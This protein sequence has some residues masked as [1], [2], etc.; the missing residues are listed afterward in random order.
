MTCYPLRSASAKPFLLPMSMLSRRFEELLLG[1]D[2]L[3]LDE[4]TLDE[5]ASR[6]LR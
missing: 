5:L 2:K 3:A 1:L 6:V 4:L